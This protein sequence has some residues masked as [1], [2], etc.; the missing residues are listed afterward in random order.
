MATRIETIITKSRYTLADVNK[1]RWSDDR[2]LSLL[3]DAYQDIASHTELL[4]ATVDIPLVPNQAEYLLPADAYLILRASVAGSPISLSTHE[5]FDELST[6]RILTDR[7][8]YESD[9]V[10]SGG[11]FDNRSLISWQDDTGSEVTAIITD[12][13]NPDLVRVY[14]IPNED[15]ASSAYTFENANI[16]SFVG[17]EVLGVVTGIDDYTFDSPFGLASSFFDPNIDNEIYDSVF[18]VVTNVAETDSFV[19]IQYIS[20]PEELTTVEDILRIP[21]MWDKALRYYIIAH[22]YDDDYDTRNQEKSAK[23]LALYER[24]L[25]TAEKSNERDHTRAAN[26]PSTYRTVFEQ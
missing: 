6:K 23:H 17:D 1:E 16:V 19:R 2:L 3:S 9:Y 8:Q 22:A 24:E 4:K 21:S 15:I 26:N 12:K 5:R 7:S 20:V 13:L 10:Y 18:G 11:D 14:P 25:Q